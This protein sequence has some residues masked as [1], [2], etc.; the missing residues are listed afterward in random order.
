MFME[1]CFMSTGVSVR[2]VQAFQVL[3]SV[4]IKVRLIHRYIY[5]YNYMHVC[6]IDDCMYEVKTVVCLPCGPCGSV[7]RRAE[8]GGDVGVT[9]RKAIPGVLIME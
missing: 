8:N 2:N 5:T 9:Q 4:F 7:S 6:C 1:K 3:Q